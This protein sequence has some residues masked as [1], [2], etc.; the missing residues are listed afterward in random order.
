M[1]KQLGRGLTVDD[2]K[3]V[4]IN[5]GGVEPHH[6]IGC[7]P[8]LTATRASGAGMWVPYFGRA[9]SISE[10][11]RLQGLEWTMRNCHGFSQAKLGHFIGNSFS[12][13]VVARI[14][15]ACLHQTDLV[16]AS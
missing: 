15:D 12:V 10:M 5:C 9:L 4:V 11:K 14:L 13:P 7:C 6:M 16:Q 8:C 3:D 2:L 1:E